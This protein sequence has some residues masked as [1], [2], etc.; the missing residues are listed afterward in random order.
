M[1][2]SDSWI[3]QN[4]HRSFVL[5]PPK[6]PRCP[7]ATP[8]SARSAPKESRSP[9]P[10]FVANSPRNDSLPDRSVA[11]SAS[12]AP[13]VSEYHL[14]LWSTSVKSAPFCLR[15]V[16]AEKAPYISRD[17]STAP[18]GETS[19]S[20]ADRIPRSALP[21]RR[22]KIRC[23]AA[24]LRIFVKSFCLPWWMGSG[25]GRSCPR[26]STATGFNSSRAFC[27][28]PKLDTWPKVRWGSCQKSVG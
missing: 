16:I 5:H 8:Q 27:Q 20:H 19:S 22:K 2:L 3:G 4:E 12:T 25:G 9:E 6:S 21:P 26:V 13:H 23:P 24:H 15:W 10:F 18:T 11:L 28:L 1:R 14:Q 7:S 17:S